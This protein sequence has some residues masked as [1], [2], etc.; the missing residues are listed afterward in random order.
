MIYKEYNKTY[1]FGNNINMYI[2]NDEQKCWQSI[3]IR[4]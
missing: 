1:D 3:L 2:A 4:I